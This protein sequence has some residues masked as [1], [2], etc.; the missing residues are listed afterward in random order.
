MMKKTLC[1]LL[2]LLTALT[3]FG[4]GNT[5]KTTG[6][7]SKSVNDVL[8]EQ[9]AETDGS[10]QQTQ[11]VQSTQ[12]PQVTID[13][14]STSSCGDIDVDLTQLSSTMV[15]S[16][17]YN[18]LTTPD[19]YRGKTVKMRGQFSLYHDDSTG[20][21]YYACVI[22][23]ATACCSQGLEFVLAGDYSYP[24]DYPE[25]GTEIT[26]V[27]EFDT[28]YEGEYMYCNLVNASFA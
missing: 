9:M 17:V 6:S 26:V 16:E 18:M 4:C 27:G 14:S 11:E 7:G 8:E 22:A 1:M 13:K 28:Y 25:L 21:N 23:D 5:S 10:V 20:N 12:S 3:L 15:Y 2:A 19:S 24:E